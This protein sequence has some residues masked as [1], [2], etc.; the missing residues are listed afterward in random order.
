MRPALKV[1][2]LRTVFVLAIPLTLAMVNPVYGQEKGRKTKSN[3]NGTENV[4]SQPTQILP[5]SSTQINVI[6]Q[7][8]P[9]PQK[10]RAENH[11]ESYLRRLF[12]PENLPNIGLF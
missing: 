2:T 6:N 3:Q 12:S 9:D 1:R 5:P 8:A 10:D 11:P 7:Q 4:N